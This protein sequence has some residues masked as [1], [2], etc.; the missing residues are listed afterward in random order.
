MRNSTVEDRIIDHEAYH[1]TVSLIENG[2]LR[3]TVQL[4]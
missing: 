4:P 1:N 3:V 2:S